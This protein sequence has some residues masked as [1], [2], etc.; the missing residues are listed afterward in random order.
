M[1]TTSPT[2]PA[3]PN[4]GYSYIATPNGVRAVTSSPSELADALTL[5]AQ[6]ARGKSDDAHEWA[7]NGGDVIALRDAFATVAAQLPAVAAAFDDALAQLVADPQ[8]DIEQL[9]LA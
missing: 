1:T 7:A 4:V 9:N 6:C 5:I 3:A 8:T 2:S